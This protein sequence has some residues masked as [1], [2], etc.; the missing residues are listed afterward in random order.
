MNKTVNSRV[1]LILFGLVLAVSIFALGML[2]NKGLGWFA[3]ND[4]V[5]AAGMSV[6]VNADTLITG[7]LESYPVTVIEGNAYTVSYDR[8][9]YSLPTDDPN[10]ISY[11]EYKKAL[12]VI[13]T[14]DAHAAGTVHVLLSASGGADTIDNVADNKI[15]NCIQISAATLSADGSVATKGGTSYSFVTIS[16]GAATKTEEINFG[17]FDV[18]EGENKLCFLIEYSDALLRYISEKILSLNTGDLLVNYE[19]DLTFMV[20]N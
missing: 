6:S 14:L 12:V 2:G 16:D 4:E 15:S 7:G 10:G 1:T 3:D 18:V 5:D 9:M 13:I 19:N 17:Y 20:V 8:Q 11:S